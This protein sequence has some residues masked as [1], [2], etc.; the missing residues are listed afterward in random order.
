VDATPLGLPG[1]RQRSRAGVRRRKSRVCARQRPRDAHH[2]YARSRPS[3]E[4][5]NL[6]ETAKPLCRD[7]EAYLRRVI[8]QLRRWPH[9]D[10]NRKADE[11]CRCL[12]HDPAW[13]CG[14][15]HAGQNRL[16]HVPRDRH[17]GL[18]EAGGTL[19]NAQ[20]MAAHESPRTTK[21]YDRAGDEITLDEV[22]RITRSAHLSVSFRSS[23][24]VIEF[25]K[26]QAKDC[27]ISE[28]EGVSGRQQSS[29]S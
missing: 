10:S 25:G 11:P 15:W 27:C 17:H 23:P 3:S 6:I 7:P 19:E 16:P 26:L 5:C 12:A 8:E 14:S 24:P 22:E 4:L 13:R 9:R 1:F 20:V 2:R 18:L 28:S 29:C 21:L